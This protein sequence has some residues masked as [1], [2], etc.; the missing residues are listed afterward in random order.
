MQF[1][2][3]EMESYYQQ[4]QNYEKKIFQRYIDQ[5][6]PFYGMYRISF[7]RWNQFFNNIFFNNFNNLLIIKKVDYHR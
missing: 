7:N 4:A 2:I 1:I 5:C 6:K 3:L